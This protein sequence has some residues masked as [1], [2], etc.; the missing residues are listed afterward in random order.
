MKLP[1]LHD[2]IERCDREAV[3]RLL[4]EGA[5]PEERDPYGYNALMRAVTPFGGHPP[6][7]AMLLEAGA[8]PDSRSPDGQDLETFAYEAVSSATEAMDAKEIARML[9][10]ARA[11]RG[12]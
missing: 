3:A 9:A 7:V 10:A 6:L 1:P 8:D 12:R 5:D 4:A 11:A 2:A